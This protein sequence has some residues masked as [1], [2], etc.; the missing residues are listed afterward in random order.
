M[1]EVCGPWQLAGPGCKVERAPHLVAWLSRPRPGAG[2]VEAGY[3]PPAAPPASTALPAFVVEGI[4][5]VRAWGGL[6]CGPPAGLSV[7]PP[8]V[9]ARLAA[10]RCTPP[11]AP[12][13]AQALFAFLEG[14]ATNQLRRVYPVRPARADAWL[15]GEIGRAARDPGALGVFRCGGSIEGGALGAGRA[16]CGGC[17]QGC[18]LARRGTMPLPLPHTHAPQERVLPA[19]APRPQLPHCPALWQAHPGAAGARA[20]RR[21]CRG[22]PPP[23]CHAPLRLYACPVGTPC[24]IG[25]GI[26]PNHPPACLPAC[27]PAWIIVP[28]GV[29][30]P[31]NN[32]PGRADDLSRTC[33]NVEVGGRGRGAASAVVLCLLVSPPLPGTSLLPPRPP[34]PCRWSSWTQGTAPTMR[35]RSK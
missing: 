21:A 16:A 35:C 32:A 29:K 13:P 28:Q 3:V 17:V 20:G 11:A 22:R 8:H 24:G 26:G 7:R 5:R 19:A 9:P 15:G 1:R 27:L 23:L 34:L 14:D 2:K 10:A 18:T 31:L 12:F 6:R 33:P 30:D 4:S 25:K